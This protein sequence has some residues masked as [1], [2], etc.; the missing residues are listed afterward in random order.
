MHVHRSA[1]LARITTPSRSSTTPRFSPSLL[2]HNQLLQNSTSP[3]P[4]PQLEHQ[5]H[6]QKNKQTTNTLNPLLATPLPQT[7]QPRAANHPRAAVHYQLAV[8]LE[9]TS[10]PPHP[11]RQTNHQT[12]RLTRRSTAPRDN[13]LRDYLSK[14]YPSQL[15]PSP[16]AKLTYQ[17]INSRHPRKTTGLRIGIASPLETSLHPVILVRSEVRGAR[18]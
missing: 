16:I 13:F 5:H 1:N 15:Y 9:Y 7:I 18:A 12:K 8:S 6:Q 2:P 3:I 17:P 4:I 14:L 10:S 11:S